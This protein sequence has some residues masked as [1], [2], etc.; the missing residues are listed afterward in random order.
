LFFFFFFFFFFF[1]A[2]D[3]IRDDLVTGVQTCALPIWALLRQPDME[4]PSS[5]LWR[6]LGLLQSI[7]T[8]VLIVAAAWIV[9]WILAHPVVGT[10]DLPVVGPIPT[11]LVLLVAGLVAGYL[12]ARV[13]S[14]HA[15]WVG[16][17]WARRVATD[18]RQAVERAVATDAFAAIDR[19]EAARSSLGNALR[20]A[21]TAKAE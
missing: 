17:R 20:D 15:G 6:L 9:I 2:E 14:L 4:P 13:L 7:D 1:Q 16:R 11:P 21:S 18:V 5:W 8:L 19:L 10:V 3:G 12:L